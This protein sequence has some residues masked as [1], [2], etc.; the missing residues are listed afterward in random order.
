MSCCVQAQHTFP[1]PLEEEPDD[2]HLQASHSHHQPTFDNAKIKY[3][4][5][6]ALD[7][8]EIPILPR[9]EVLL[10]PIDRRQV[11][12]HLQYRLFQ[13]RSLLRWGGLLG[14]EQCRGTFPFNLCAR[15]YQNG[16]QVEDG[17]VLR[18][19]S[20]PIFLSTCSSHCRSRTYIRRPLS[21]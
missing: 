3:S 19:Q 17:I 10:I 4:R 8:T 21:L 15:K 14:G 1:C 18:S 9:P 5:L 7:R 2:K 13:R 12:G 6:S 16:S 11:S 20:R